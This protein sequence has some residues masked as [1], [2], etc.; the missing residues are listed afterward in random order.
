MSQ[1]SSA[2]TQ[3]Q[4]IK[5]RSNKSLFGSIPI[6]FYFLSCGLSRK[7]VDMLSRCGFCPCF[8]S[9][10][11]GHQALADSRMTEAQ[12]IARMAHSTGWDNT[13]ISTSIHVEQRSLAPPKVQVG[14]TSMIYLL[15]NAAMQDLELHP[16][17]EARMSAPMITFNSDIRP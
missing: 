5:N 1:K 14:T 2:I 9:L 11:A 8:K 4:L 16:I 3:L 6:G 15:R 17:L 13:Q 7:V 12:V 10:N